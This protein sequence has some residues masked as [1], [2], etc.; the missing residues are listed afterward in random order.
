MC[1]TPPEHALLAWRGLGLRYASGP[2][3]VFPDLQLTRGQHLLLRGV[4]GSGK[5]SLIALLAGLR[6]ATTGE[7]WLAERRLS[8][9]AP[10]QLDAWR[11]RQLGLLPQRLH[12]CE[13]LS[14]RD[15]LLLPFTAVGEAVPA[16]RIE[17]LAER[18]GLTA[19]LDRPP[20]RLSGG[21]MQRG[22][23]ARALVRE[24]ALL[25]LDEP[26]SSLDDAATAA[27][28][29]LVLSLIRERGVSVLVATHDARVVQH[30]TAALGESLH[31]LTL[32]GSTP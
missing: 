10:A 4:S 12:L 15:N 9:L 8:A 22:A 11:G 6:R 2:Q 16:G 21:Q 31:T 13:A 25:L 27:L 20:H 30:L 7:I 28:L 19:L 26:S 3:L 18:L 24:P 5:S 23:L 17:V 29:D 14:L 32:G 1:V